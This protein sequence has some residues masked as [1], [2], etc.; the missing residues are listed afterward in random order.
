MGV[1]H[2][3]CR[4]KSSKCRTNSLRG[5]LGVCGVTGYRQSSQQARHADG[6]ASADRAGNQQ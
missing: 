6:L 5:G 2:L 3:H 1:N 4:Q